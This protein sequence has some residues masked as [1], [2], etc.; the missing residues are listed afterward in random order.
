MV[1]LDLS[2]ALV[3]LYLKVTL[4]LSLW[5]VNEITS[6]LQLLFSLK[7]GGFWGGIFARATSD[8]TP[9]D[10]VYASK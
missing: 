9:N 2:R 5:V 4:A 10:S 7:H 8:L 3:G 1:R 6:T